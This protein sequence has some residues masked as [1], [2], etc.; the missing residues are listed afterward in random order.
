MAKEA[1]IT[2]QAGRVI[3]WLG[4]KLYR[5]GWQYSNQESGGRQIWK[6]GAR[7]TARRQGKVIEGENPKRGIAGQEKMHHQRKQAGQEKVNHQKGLT[8]QEKTHHQ[9]GQVGQGKG[10]QKQG[11]GWK[12]AP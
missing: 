6:I 9:K 11:S 1:G 12:K 4:N 10:W 2:M 3:E 7:K 8:G 5:I